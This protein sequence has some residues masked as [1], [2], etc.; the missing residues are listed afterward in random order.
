MKPRE[1]EHGSEYAFE[2]SG[3]SF[4]ANCLFVGIN[5]DLEVSDGFDDTLTEAGDPPEWWKTDPDMAEMLAEHFTPE[6]KAELS[7][8][9]ISLWQEYKKKHAHNALDKPAE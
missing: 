7:D 4:M 1:G 6:E 5:P 9:M 3:R 2:C 8:F